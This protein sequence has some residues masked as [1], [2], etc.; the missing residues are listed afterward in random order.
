MNNEKNITHLLENPFFELVRHDVACPYFVEVDTVLN[1]KVYFCTLKNKLW[2]K[3]L[4]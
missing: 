1:K 3:I 4:Y 2:S